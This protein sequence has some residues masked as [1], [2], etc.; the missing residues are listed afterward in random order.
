MT[1]SPA[2]ANALSEARKSPAESLQKHLRNAIRAVLINKPIS[3]SSPSL[4]N[5]LGKLIRRLR[6][7]F[8]RMV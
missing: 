4:T 6:L 2:K 8:G 3:V 1:L 5:H 7:A